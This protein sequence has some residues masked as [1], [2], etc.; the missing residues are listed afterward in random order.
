MQV[1]GSVNETLPVILHHGGGFIRKKT[2]RG[3]H[4]R[5][6]SPDPVAHHVSR[7]TNNAMSTATKKQAKANAIFLHRL[8]LSSSSLKGP[9]E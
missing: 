8:S 9:S 6:W 3:M 5:G 7:S 2:I 1:T 4:Q